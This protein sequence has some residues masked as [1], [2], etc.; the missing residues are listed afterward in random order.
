MKRSALIVLLAG[1]GAALGSTVSVWRQ[2]EEN[3][4]SSLEVFAFFGVALAV[5]IL[6]AFLVA[7]FGGGKSR[8]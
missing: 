4:L 5:T 2:A 1:S 3:G 7:R 8:A 6:G